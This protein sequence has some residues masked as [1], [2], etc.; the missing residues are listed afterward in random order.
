MGIETI[1]LTALSVGMSA[2]QGQQQM[3]NAKAQA[4]AIAQ[5]G[6][7]DAERKARET[8]LKAARVKSSFLNSGLTLEGT[9]MNV[10]TGT[11]D[12][13]LQDVN[14]IIGNANARSKNIMSEARSAALGDLMQSVAGASFSGMGSGISPG[15]I[16]WNAAPTGVAQSNGITWN[17]PRMAGF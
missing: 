14:Q 4:N 9:P 11:Y 8:Q 10:I 6:A 5:Q 1:A 17:T 13:G 2:I 12:V 15:D 3:K 16:S 7:L